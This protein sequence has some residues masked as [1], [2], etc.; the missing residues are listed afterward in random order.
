[1]KCKVV[2]YIKLDQ[3]QEALNVLDA[4]PNNDLV[5]ER[6]Y[7]YYR[8]KKISEALQLLSKVPSPK[9]VNVLELEAQIVCSFVNHHLLYSTFFNLF[10]HLCM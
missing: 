1:V 6:A 9:P 7:C 8:S 5:F 10:S 4:Y 3:F 2:A